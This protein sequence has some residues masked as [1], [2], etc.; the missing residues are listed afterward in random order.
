VHATTPFPAP[1]PQRVA[2]VGDPGP[3]LEG[4]L[5]RAAQAL[6]VPLVGAEAVPSVADATR[7]AAFDGW[8]T[9]AVGRAD[10]R[11]ILLD[12]A[13]LV[14]VVRS[15][16]P[17]TL[18]GLVRRTVRRLRTDQPEVDV[19]WLEA[20]ALTRPTLPVARLDGPDAVED[21][22]RRLAADLDD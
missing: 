15:E 9:T 8:L 13:D 12:R 17:G 16:A 2:V 21:W 5:T 20:L 19:S 7:L 18:R 3:V 4:F 22:L 6:D 1:S 14:V 11:P 10:L